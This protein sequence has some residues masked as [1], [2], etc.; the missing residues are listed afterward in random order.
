MRSPNWPLDGIHPDDA[1]HIKLKNA[2]VAAIDGSW[3]NY[4]AAYLP[5]SAKAAFVTFRNIGHPNS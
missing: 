5:S 1:G 2:F 3:S 4:E